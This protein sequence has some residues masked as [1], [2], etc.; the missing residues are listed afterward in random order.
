MTTAFKKSFPIT[1]EYARE[2]EIMSSGYKRQGFQVNPVSAQAGA[3]CVP[4]NCSVREAFRYAGADFTVATAPLYLADGTESPH[5]KAAIRCDDHESAIIGHVGNSW[6]PVQ[7]SAMIDLFQSLDG[8]VQLNNIVV[9]GNGQKIFATAQLT[10]EHEITDGH[11]IRRYIHAFNDHSGGGSFGIHFSDQ[12]LICAN[13]LRFL[14]GR[15]MSQAMADSTGT[16]HRHT[17]SVTAFAQNLPNLIDIQNQNFRKSV[18]EL[19]AMRSTELTTG[20]TRAV[21][22]QL[23]AKELVKPVKTK[24]GQEMIERKRTLDDVKSASRISR[25]MEEGYGMDAP[26][27]RGTNYQLFQAITQHFTHDTFKSKEEAENGMTTET[28]R[29]RLEDL[30]SGRRNAQQ[31]NAARTL[32]LAGVN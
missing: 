5:G 32:C 4:E 15:A 2:K 28:A 12:N 23:F 22:E 20:F 27:V 11:V 10:A 14:T 25:L 7:N 30:W 16:R 1:Q 18:S 9:T 26:G 24:E 19:D 21:L 6:V 3:D 13:Q 8:L 31:I 17:K 29:N